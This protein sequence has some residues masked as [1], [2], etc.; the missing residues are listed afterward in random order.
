MA[1]TAKLT[2]DERAAQIITA[3][4]VRVVNSI[5]RTFDVT[6]QSRTEPYRVNLNRG[7]CECKDFE[8]NGFACKHMLAAQKFE[9]LQS[10]GRATAAAPKFKNYDALFAALA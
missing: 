4:G 5:D 8:R 3:N 9:T 1:N 2:R 10:A 6:A 7:T